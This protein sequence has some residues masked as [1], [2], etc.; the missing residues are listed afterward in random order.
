METMTGEKLME[1]LD[2]VVVYA[3]LLGYEIWY[4]MVLVQFSGEEKYMVY[5]NEDLTFSI[6]KAYKSGSCFTIEELKNKLIDLL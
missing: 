1:E 5:Q 2:D 3:R 4:G 6:D